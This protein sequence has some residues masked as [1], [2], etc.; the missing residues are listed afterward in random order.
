MIVRIER[1]T[2]SS[3]SVKARMTRRGVRAAA[4]SGDGAMASGVFGLWGG[5]VERE[6]TEWKPG[7]EAGAFRPKRREVG[8]G[9]RQRCRCAMADCRG[10]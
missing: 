5:G 3:K 9:G 8:E 2:I 6:W 10:L 7:A 4:M 1:T